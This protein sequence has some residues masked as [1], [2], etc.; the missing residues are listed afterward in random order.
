MQ[1]RILIPILP[2]AWLAYQAASPIWYIPLVCRARH[3]ITGDPEDKGLQCDNYSDENPYCFHINKDGKQIKHTLSKDG[4]RAKQT[5][6]N[7]NNYRT[8]LFHLA[9]QLNFQV[10]AAGM[11]IYFHYPVPIRWTK[12]KKD[13]MH[14]QMKSSKSDVIN[15]LKAFEDALT[16][17][18]ELIGQ[19]SGSGKFWFKPELVDEKLRQGYIEIL[20]N[21]PLHN[22]YQVELQNPYASIEMEDI[23]T[24]RE[25]L[26]SRKEEL[27]KQ[28]Q[29]SDLLTK[30][31]RVIKPLSLRKQKE[32]F[33][34]SDNIK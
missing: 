3:M 4:R 18:D 5:I 33:K 31:K 25:K 9:K 20:I 24:R 22:P 21:Q 23:V 1:N 6:E 12:K 13:V 34:K 17:Y 2:K 15:N 10:Q 14:G 8:E 30:K 7:Y 27:K 26:K 29:N 19:Y 32:L 16:G 11:A 28:R